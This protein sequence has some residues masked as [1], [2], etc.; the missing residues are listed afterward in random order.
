MGTYASDHTMIKAGAIQLA[1]GGY[2]ILNIR[3][4]L[5]NPNVWEGFK[6]VIRT[7]EIRVEDP[8][9][10]FGF[11]APQG[12]RAQPVPVELKI[13]VMGMTPSITPHAYDEDFW[14]MFKVKA[15]LTFR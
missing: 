12:M 7:K 13:I 10:S 2:L 15:D 9:E 1:N 3:D 14:E 6:R 4:L 5:L 8:W 11:L